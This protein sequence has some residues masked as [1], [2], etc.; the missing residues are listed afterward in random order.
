[1]K[2]GITIKEIEKSNK[3]DLENIFMGASNIG[4]EETDITYSEY[5]DFLQIFETS[6]VETEGIIEEMR[7]TKDDDE[8]KHMK[9]IS[10]I[11]SDVYD[12][13]VVQIRKGMTEKQIAMNIKRMLAQSG[14]DGIPEEVR[15][16]SG[17]NSSNM[18]FL[19][20]NRRLKSGD[21][22][23]IY[24]SGSY[25][26]Y[27]AKMT[28]TIF[29]ERATEQQQ[30]EYNKLIKLH[31]SLLRN[32]R[33]RASI[34]EITKEYSKE[35][36]EINWDIKYYLAHGIGL[37]LS[38]APQFV[39]NTNKEIKERMTIVIE[40]GIY[41]QGYGIKIADTIAITESNFELYTKSHRDIRIIS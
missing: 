22:V 15:V 9:Y 18:F 38:E 21:V 37:E 34:S 29:V 12:R 17:E 4:I 40:P 35:L 5:R 28:R 11:L 6:L 13:S 26:D 20:T 2:I 10:K 24:L 23:V 3:R 19:P 36:E 32:I 39:T 33:S 1:M 25:R 8:L 16:Q 41:K 27:H 14:L 31:D 7:E 30:E